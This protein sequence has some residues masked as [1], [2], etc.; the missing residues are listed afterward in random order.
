MMRR[1]SGDLRQVARRPRSGAI[2]KAG[3]DT[4]RSHPRQQRPPAS[5]NYGI[6]KATTFDWR[7]AGGEWQTQARDFTTEAAL[8]ACCPIVE[9]S[10]RWC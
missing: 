8:R 3:H 1:R 2:A 10:V 9:R 5:D 7:R 4:L 6:L